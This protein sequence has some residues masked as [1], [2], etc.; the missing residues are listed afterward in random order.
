MPP[1][2]GSVRRLYSSRRVPVPIV[3]GVG[4]LVNPSRDATPDPLTYFSM[5]FS[6]QLCSAQLGRLV[7]LFVG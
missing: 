5:L 1:R 4:S 7:S 6:V 3:F 2:A